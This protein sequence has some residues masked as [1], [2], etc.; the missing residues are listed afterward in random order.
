MLFR[1]YHCIELLTTEY[2][3]IKEIVDNNGGL[4][5]LKEFVKGK[6]FTRDEEMITTLAKCL[7]EDYTNGTLIKYKKGLY[8]L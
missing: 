7:Y 1:G 6:V 5:Q 8:E 2:K 4:E 3:A